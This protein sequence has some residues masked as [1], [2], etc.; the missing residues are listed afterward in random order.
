MFSAIV[1]NDIKVGFSS[2]Q[3][4][5][6]LFPSPCPAAFYP[7]ILGAVGR[8]CQLFKLGMPAVGRR[9]SLNSQAEKG[10]NQPTKEM[11]NTNG[12][13]N[14]E[15]AYSDIQPKKQSETTARIKPLWRQSL[16]QQWKGTKS[17]S[18]EGF[19]D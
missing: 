11:V 17:L 3:K 5:S 8:R 4:P 12:K 9:K 10:W 16:G 7:H 1:L 13:T 15:F 6:A 2:F 19:L 18:L 14:E